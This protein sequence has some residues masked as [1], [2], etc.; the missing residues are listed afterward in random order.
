MDMIKLENHLKDN[1]YRRI[2]LGENEKYQGIQ[3]SW[4]MGRSEGGKN[5][6]YFLEGDRLKA[7]I[8]N[9]QNEKEESY[10]LDAMITYNKVHIVGN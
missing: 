3:I 1:P 2:I 10:L 6:H 9:S 5:R 8:A 4:L 7:G